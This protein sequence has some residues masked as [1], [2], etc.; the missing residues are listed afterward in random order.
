MGYAHI[1]R[2][3]IHDSNP[4]TGL[5]YEEYKDMLVHSNHDYMKYKDF[6][7]KLI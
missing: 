5:I 2:Y 1:T 7:R 6:T 3:I 4:Y